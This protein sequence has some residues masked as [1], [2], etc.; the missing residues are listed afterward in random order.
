MKE[1]CSFLAHPVH[2]TSNQQQCA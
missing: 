2:C 1:W